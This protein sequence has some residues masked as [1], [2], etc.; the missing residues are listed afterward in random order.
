M[1]L[2]M[3]QLTLPA[4][5]ACSFLLQMRVLLTETCLL[6]A[7]RHFS[8]TNTAGPAEVF[9][10]AARSLATALMVEGLASW[11]MLPLFRPD[12]WL[13][14]GL[15]LLLYDSAGLVTA[16]LLAH[17][18]A[19]FCFCGLPVPAYVV[20]AL[21]NT[22]SEHRICSDC[23]WQNWPRGADAAD[24]GAAAPTSMPFENAMP[25]SCR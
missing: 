18:S 2:T 19:G 22:P 13:L 6:K 25:H 14:I 4:S 10:A 21:S 8:A 17:L 7:F 15:S 16:P 12:H 9:A 24:L 5:P 1:S 23:H 20:E 3:V 11:A